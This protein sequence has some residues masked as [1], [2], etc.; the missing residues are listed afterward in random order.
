M[1]LL[2]KVPCG[3]IAAIATLPCENAFQTPSL[4]SVLPGLGWV[5]LSLLERSRR[6]FSVARFLSLLIDHLSPVFQSP[7]PFHIHMENSA[8]ASSAPSGRPEPTHPVAFALLP[9][10]VRS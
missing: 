2:V 5:T 4:R 7:P 9:I 3:M 10:R 8:C 1:Y 6:K